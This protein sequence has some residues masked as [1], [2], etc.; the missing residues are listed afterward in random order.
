MLVHKQIQQQGD[1]TTLKQKIGGLDYE[2][3]G[4]CYVIE[5]VFFMVKSQETKCL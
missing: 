5:K 4:D 1:S 2:K 3:E